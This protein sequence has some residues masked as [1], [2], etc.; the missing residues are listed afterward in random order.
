LNWNVAHDTAHASWSVRHRLLSVSLGI[1]LGLRLEIAV[2][3]RWFLW[4]LGSSRPVA[5]KIGDRWS[6]ENILG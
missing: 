3:P 5:R 6:R 4:G 1:R 2:A